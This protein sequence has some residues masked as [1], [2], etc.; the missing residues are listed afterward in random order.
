[1]ILAGG[2][3][4]ANVADAIA[5]VRPF[6]VDVSSGVES[7]PGPQGSRPH[8]FLHRARASRVRRSHRSST[9]PVTAL[10]SATK[11]TLLKSLLEGRSARRARPLR[12]LRWP[13]H[14][15]NA[16]AR[17]RSPDRGRAHHAHAAGFPGRIHG[18]AS[19]LGGSP[20]G[21]V[22]DAAVVAALGRGGVVQARGS[23][24]HRRAQDQQLARASAARQ[25][26]GRQAR[27][28]RDR[29]GPAR[30]RHRGRVRASAC[31]APSTWAK[32]TWRARR[33]TSAAC[34]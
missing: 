26:H 29:R 23:R 14:P 22:A 20:H 6:G 19:R 11:A 24:A 10:D 13:L 1:M 7:A 17:V 8:R 9:A 12:P 4:P 27:D 18:G 34:A 25:A 30:R 31:P 16:G 21:A 32:W 15:R 2:L 33:R 3:G 5:Q 28:R